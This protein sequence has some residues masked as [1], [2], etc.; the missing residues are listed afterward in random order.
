MSSNED[1]DEKR[2]KTIRLVAEI[3]EGLQ[4]PAATSKGPLLLGA[5]FMP[6]IELTRLLNIN[7]FEDY[8]SFLS[9]LTAAIE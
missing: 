5:A 3:L 6:Y 9:K 1:K 4:V 7:F 2:N 8:A